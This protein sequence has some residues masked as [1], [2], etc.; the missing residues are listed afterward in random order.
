MGSR[1]VVTGRAADR[2]TN[3]AAATVNR[4]VGQSGKDLSTTAEK[5]KCY[6]KNS[7]ITPEPLVTV[8]RRIFRRKRTHVVRNGV[9]S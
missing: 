9:L 2:V 3:R 4:Y 7:R 1:V 8:T 6:N 5:T